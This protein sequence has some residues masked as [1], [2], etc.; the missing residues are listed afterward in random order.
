MTATTTM[1]IPKCAAVVT[2]ISPA[3]I[4]PTGHNNNHLSMLESKVQIGWFHPDFTFCIECTDGTKESTKDSAVTSIDEDTASDGSSTQSPATPSLSFQPPQV[5]QHT[6]GY[7]NSNPAV[8]VNVTTTTARQND[9]HSATTVTKST[10]SLDSTNNVVTAATAPFHHS[11]S[12]LLVRSTLHV[13]GICCA[14]EVPVVQQIV[15]PWRSHISIATRR[16]TIFH[17]PVVAPAASMARLLTNNGFAARV[18]TDGSSVQL[19][20]L[21]SANGA[22]SPNEWLDTIQASTRRSP[23][24]ESTVAVSDL[25]PQDREDI[26][27]IMRQNFTPLGVRAMHPIVTARGGP[28]GGGQGCIK[29]EHDPVRI[30][31]AVVC[32]VL[33]DSGFCDVTILTDGAAERLYLPETSS[34][35]SSSSTTASHEMSGKE[36]NDYQSPDNHHDDKSFEVKMEWHVVLSGIFWVVSMTATLAAHGSVWNY[37]IY[38]GMLS[39]LF[40]LP[41]VLKKAL[42]TIRRGQFDSNVMMVIAALGACILGEWDEAASVSF[43]FACSDYMEARASSRARQALSAIVHLRPDHASVINAVTKEITIVPADHVPVH[44]L[45][46]VRT[47][48]KIAAD[49]VVVEGTS[50]VDNSSLT[51]ESKPVHVTVGSVVAGGSINIGTTQLVVRTTVSVQDSAVSRLIRLVEDAQSNRSPTEKMVDTFARAYTPAVVATAAIM[52]TL[53]WLWGFETGRYWTLNALILIV[54]ACPCALAISTPV[55]YAAGLAATAQR[56]I[57]CKGGASLEA[58]GS[59]KTVVLDKTGTITQGNFAVTA[60]ELIGN[61]RTRKEMLTLLSVLEAPSSHPLSAALVQAASRE[62]VSVPTDVDMKEHTTLAGEGVTALVNGKQVFVGNRRLFERINM[63]ESLPLDCKVQS[64]GWGTDHGGTVGFIGV[65][66]EGIIG[67]YCVTDVVRSEAKGAIDAL[68][69]AGIQVVMLTGDGD[70]AAQ[71]VAKRIG[72]PAS[73]VHSQLLPDDKLHFVAS[74]KSQSPRRPFNLFYQQPN[75]LFCGDGVNDAPALAFADIGVSMGEGAALAMEM[76]D[77][78]LMDSN[79]TK[80]PFMIEMGSKVVQIIRENIIVSLVCKIVVV[81]LTFTGYMTLLFAIAS[82]VGVMLLV[83]LNGMRLLPPRDEAVSIDR[84]KISRYHSRRGYS[85]LST[86]SERSQADAA[87]LDQGLL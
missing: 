53:P 12:T 51:G 60:L 66:N 7:N 72:L 85:G 41:P 10:T 39:V 9:N 67:S 33:E 36:I 19:L 16:V 21:S 61:R 1:M 30:P 20:H 71:A 38:A 79:L 22:A 65:E 32:T 49:G 2:K 68:L 86:G 29:V 5:H 78:T 77:V 4:E 73:S 46:S 74:L 31:I 83:T 75:V 15:Q 25:L 76:S 40:G 58:L 45:L 52:A 42:Y 59:V 17:D 63:Y 57:V 44:T 26:R 14:S 55:T 64:E 35:S 37:F 28:H 84:Q 54:I 70:G 3:E 18:V 81:G 87:E 13:Q 24:V 11:L 82:D 43:L 23:F 69:S 6:L 47:G 80:L 27:Q 8:V 34:S 62:S 50:S 48:D 56:G